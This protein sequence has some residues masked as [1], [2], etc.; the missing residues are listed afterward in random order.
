MRDYGAEEME[1]DKPFSSIFMNM[2]S[3]SDDNDGNEM[4]NERLFYSMFSK[5]ET[6][7]NFFG[8]LSNMPEEMQ[9]NFMNFF[10]MGVQTLPAI[11]CTAREELYGCVSREA[12]VLNHESQGF[13]NLYAVN[14]AFYNNIGPLY[15]VNLPPDPNSENEANALF[16][17]F[18]A[19]LITENGEMTPFANQFFS[20][21]ITAASPPHCNN[22]AK[23]ML[24]M[25]QMMM[26]NSFLPFTIEQFQEMAA[27][28]YNPNA[29]TPRNFLDGS[30]DKIFGSCPELPCSIES[31][32]GCT[33][34]EDCE[35]LNLYWCDSYCSNEN[36]N[37]CDFEHLS[38]C[39]DQTSCLNAGGNFCDSSCINEDCELPLVCN[40]SN[41]DLCNNMNSC[42]SANGYWCV[43]N[44][45]ENECDSNSELGQEG[46]PC[47][48]YH[49]CSEE[50]SCYRTYG[51][52]FEYCV[53][54]KSEGES[55]EHF[56]PCENNL[57]CEFN[58]ESYI[59]QCKKLSQVGQVCEWNS[60]CERNL[61]CDYRDKICKIF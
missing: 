25:F 16:G 4:A 36:C 39:L 29:P 44:C 14:K 35:E 52:Q 6:A 31:S 37:T 47:N 5:I 15:D 20:A 8:A 10:F 32:Q 30:G 34:I 11:N 59:Y 51:E 54:P 7:N 42:I 45:S 17:N 18:M 1:L 43:N 53:K 56:Y 2:G 23:G 28:L 26:E 61:Y 57:V 55:C 40:S 48:Y 50:F 13:Y 60:D 19:M 9:A 41:L 38:L 22:E 49:P 33:T 58:R 46:D 27:Q 24:M 12:E 21:I 3:T